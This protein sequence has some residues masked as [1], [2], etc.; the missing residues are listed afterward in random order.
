MAHVKG[1]S[2]A[3]QKHGGANYFREKM[4]YPQ[5]RKRRLWDDKSI[6]EELKKIMDQI[7]K[8]PSFRHIKK[9]HRSLLS[10]IY[11]RGGLKHYQQ[12]ITNK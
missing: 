8:T 1:L 7:G 12:L 9:N 4:G 10:A 6:I 2:L 3:V 5:C 11:K